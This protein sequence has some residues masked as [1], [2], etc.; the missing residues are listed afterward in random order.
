MSATAARL[1]RRLRLPDLGEG[2]S[3]DLLLVLL[4]WLTAGTVAGSHWVRGS[5]AVVS[6]A[7]AGV[8]SGIVLARLAP[9]ATTFWLASELGMLG[10]MFLATARHSSAPA[11]D[12]SAWVVSLEHSVS[13]VL[14]VAMLATAWLSSAWTAFWALRRGQ[15]PLALAP[16][17]VAMVVEVIDD[18]GLKAITYRVVAWMALAGLLLM[19]HTVARL[20]TRWGADRAPEVSSG[21]G[22]Q[23]GWALALILVAAFFVLP[24]LSTEDLSAQYFSGTSPSGSGTGDRPGTSGRGGNSLFART[25]YS[26][27]VEPGGTLVRSLSPVMEVTT[28]VALP[29]YWRG[30]DLYAVR[31]G[32]WESTSSPA[33]TVPAS[34]NQTLATDTYQARQPVHATI[35][36][37]GVPQNTIFWPGEPVR[38]AVGSQVRGLPASNAG[39]GVDVAS[40]D[41]AYARNLLPPGLTYTVDASYSTATEDQLRSAGTA[42][43]AVVRFLAVSRGAR[44]VEDIDPRV[45]SLARQVTSTQT[46]PYDK[47]KAIETYLRSDLRY[48]LDVKPPPQDQDP[49]VY[50]LFGSRVGYCEYFA[51]SMG[52]M[53]RS[54][55]IPVRL[56][57]GYGPGSTQAVQ[58]GPGRHEAEVLGGPKLV[59]ASDAHT[60][61]EVFFPNYGWIPFEPTPDPLYPVLDRSTFAAAPDAVPAPA[62]LPAPSKTNL[63]GTAVSKPSAG[64]VP[65]LVLVALTLVALA[66]FLLV[67]AVAARGPARL[68]SPEAAWR[69]LG[70][71]A[72]RR[73]QPRR[74]SDTP[75]EFSRRLARAMPGLGRAITELG[76]AYS[77]WCYRREGVADLQSRLADDA[78][79]TV[80]RAMIRELVWPH[81]GEGPV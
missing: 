2:L 51:S 36:V 9:R 21:V 62:P 56:V 41:G 7:L 70:W 32:S 45:A 25:G 26:E 3:T 11:S 29:V 38:A 14:L 73:G 52:E 30:I 48:S 58:L 53:L 15:V 27:R 40:V 6:V 60:W 68:R 39:Q 4:A 47:V 24:P 43:P 63:P 22:V 5:E 23:G 61:V 80:R 69:R 12:F 72:A 18:P 8:L 71:L 55:G 57:D 42:Y 35:K 50:F 59:R 81:Q 10:A 76:Q 31:N 28:D 37:L 20:G 34:P 79:R 75:V 78:W 16:L 33:L 1:A 65:G 66:L 67:A 13:L 54:L 46:N 19:R 44:P 17:A 74:S 49:I 64:L 77:Q